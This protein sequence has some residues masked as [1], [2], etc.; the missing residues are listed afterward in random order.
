MD[1][2]TVCLACL[3]K[4]TD[5]NRFKAI[6]I[7]A[8]N[9]SQNHLTIADNFAQRHHHAHVI[10]AQP[11]GLV[12]AVMGAMN[13]ILQ[14]PQ[15]DLILKIDEDV[16]VCT[17]WLDAM[18]E[19]YLQHKNNDNILL[20]AGLCPISSNGKEI[21]TDFIQT[22]CPSTYKRYASFSGNLD[23]NKYYHRSIWHAILNEDFCHRY[24]EYE[25]QKFVYADHIVIN[26]IL[27]DDKLKSLIYPLPTTRDPETSMGCVDELTINRALA[28][29]H[30]R[31]A[32]PTRPLI[33]HYS[34]WR[35][36]DYLRQYISIDDIWTWLSSKQKEK[37]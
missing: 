33:H 8:N 29:H 18:E 21:L 26:C 22:E 31:V 25:S 10:E 20:V 9:V 7:I 19:T 1:C 36:E 14:S 32:L 28:Q 17:G 2:F 15:N 37:D 11:K 12:P 27:F 6:Y 16:F 23:A 34:H 30:G 24:A 4:F 35:S 3:E 13:L 5:I